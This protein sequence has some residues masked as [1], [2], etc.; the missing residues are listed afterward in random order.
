MKIIFFSYFYLCIFSKNSQALP[1]L[2]LRGGMSNKHT[3]ENSLPREAEL[4][5]VMVAESS[6]SS[7]KIRG[8]PQA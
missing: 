7:Q 8:N 2:E 3:Q 1:L 4:S 5:P 6:G